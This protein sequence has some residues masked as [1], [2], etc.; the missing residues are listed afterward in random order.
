MTVDR[1]A[2]YLSPFIVAFRAQPR[3]RALQTVV[4]GRGERPP[5]VT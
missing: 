5:T 2:R 4:E 3:N 1:N